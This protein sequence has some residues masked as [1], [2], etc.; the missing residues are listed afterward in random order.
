MLAVNAAIFDPALA[1]PLCD[2]NDDGACDIQ[3]LIGVNAK[4]FGAVAHCERYPAP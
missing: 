3:D 2:T 4:T 1:T